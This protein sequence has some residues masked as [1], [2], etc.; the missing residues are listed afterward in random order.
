MN[1]LITAVEFATYRNISQKLDT[2]KIDEAISLAQQSDLVEILGEF[3]FNV[4]RNAEETSFDDLMSGSEFTYNG[5]SYEH[6]GIKALLADYAYSRFI[7]MAN[8]NLTP[9]G[10][11]KKFT[12]DSEGVDRNTIKD[13]S[14]QAQVDA[15]VKFKFIELYLFSEPTTF[16][17]YCEGKNQGTS[18]FTNRI[19]KL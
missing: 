8:V 17:R 9:F 19:S 5:L 18:F 15:G 10:V 11:Q 2:A 6:A 3:Y 13:L 14:K 12:E 1:N 4:V 7:Y 16:S